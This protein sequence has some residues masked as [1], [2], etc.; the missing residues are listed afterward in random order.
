MFPL[1]SHILKH[2]CT[3]GYLSNLSSVPHYLSSEM[4]QELTFPDVKTLWASLHPS[5]LVTEAL[6]P[7]TFVMM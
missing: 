3:L 6:V 1:T 4:N 2:L 7:I 5:G